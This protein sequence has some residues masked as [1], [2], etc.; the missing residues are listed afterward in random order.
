MTLE[1]NIELTCCK[2]VDVTALTMHEMVFY[3][4]HN[5]YLQLNFFIIK[6]TKNYEP[7]L[8]NKKG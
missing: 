8:R 6:Y 5:F 1:R 3:T 4:T 2:D 7:K